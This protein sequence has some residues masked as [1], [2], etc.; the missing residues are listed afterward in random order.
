MSEKFEKSNMFRI[1]KLYKDAANILRKYCN[2]EGSL[3]KLIYETKH[4]SDVK[5]LYGLLSNV[6][7]QYSSIEKALNITN[8]LEDQP[9]FDKSLAF[10]LASEVVRKNGPLSGR[11]KPFEVI[12]NYE[13]KIRSVMKSSVDLAV[14]SSK[15]DPMPKYVRFNTILLSEKNINEQLQKMGWNLC[16]Y[17]PGKISYD[18][19]LQFVKDLSE[20]SYMKDYHIPNLYVFS[21]K[22]EFWQTDLYINGSVLLQNKA[23]CL[24]SYIS[25]VEP[26]DIAIDACA[27]PGNKTSHLASIMNGKGR[28]IAIDKDFKRYKT[29]VKLLS[30]RGLSWVETLNCDFTSLEPSKYSDVKVIMVDPSCSSSGTN[31]HEDELS[32]ERLIG[33]STFQLKVLTHALSFP[34]VKTVVYS[35]C[36]VNEEENEMVVEKAL[37]KFSSSFSLEDVSKKL[38]GWKHFGNENYDFGRHCIRTNSHIDRCQGFFVAKFVRLASK[39]SSNQKKKRRIKNEDVDIHTSKIIKK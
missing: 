16:V 8:L 13:K 20:Y 9:K 21:S 35:T 27:A 18:E 11:S 33:L 39:S 31:V 17:D 28:L 5:R 34:N 29:M 30:G 2:K 23:S 14:K 19:F 37:A 3:Q 7:D 32:K 10:I 6:I 15:K 25:G 4:R 1:P 24:P 12:N 38:I 36:S 22:A 26:G